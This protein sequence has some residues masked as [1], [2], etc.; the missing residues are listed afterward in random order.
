MID[1][2]DV[3]WNTLIIAEIWDSFV[4]DPFL[5]LLIVNTSP[6]SLQSGQPFSPPTRE[7][8]ATKDVAMEAYFASQESDGDHKK[9]KASFVAEPIYQKRVPPMT[10]QK[11]RLQSMYKWGTSTFLQLGTLGSL[12]AV[13]LRGTIANPWEY[14]DGLQAQFK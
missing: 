10:R 2:Q 7:L 1:S 13:V 6:G 8:E 3:D 14:N 9:R 5:I 4:R 11:S 12:K